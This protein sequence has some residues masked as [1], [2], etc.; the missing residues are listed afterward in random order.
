[1]KIDRRQFLFS[2]SWLAA[3]AALWPDQVLAIGKGSRFDI[4]LLRYDGG[5]NPRPNGVRKM[6]Q[7]V[8]K[9]T[10]I[11]VSA[12]PVPVSATDRA[13]LFAHPLLLLWGIYLHWQKRNK[14]SGAADRDRED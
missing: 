5:W 13:N 3:G 14:K 2:A 12:A 8:E 10:S 1:M 4:G 11:S 9:R 7:E 6:L